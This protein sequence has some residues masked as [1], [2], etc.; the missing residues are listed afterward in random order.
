MQAEEEKKKM[1][2]VMDVGTLGQ[3]TDI[4]KRSFDINRLKKPIRPVVKQ[5]KLKETVEAVALVKPTVQQW[6][7][8]AK[9]DNKVFVCQNYRQFKTAVEKRKTD[10]K[11]GIFQGFSA[12]HYAI[13]FDNI[14]VI[15]ILL[16]SECWQKTAKEVKITAPSISEYCKYILPAGSNT[17][18][19]ALLRGKKQTI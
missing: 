1:K 7:A 5:S 4:M 12:I 16:Q 13:Y 17:L 6:F 10:Y 19:L 14:D 8:A 2:T 3:L 18:Q 9:G 15:K 11:E